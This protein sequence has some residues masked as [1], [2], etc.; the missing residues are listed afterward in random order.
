MYTA[1]NH[2]RQVSSQTSS[3]DTVHITT[4]ELLTCTKSF[5]TTLDVMATIAVMVTFKPTDNWREIAALDTD[6]HCCISLTMLEGMVVQ[7]HYIVVNATCEDMELKLIES[8]GKLLH[9]C[10]R[11]SDV[12]PSQLKSAVTTDHFPGDGYPVVYSNTHRLTLCLRFTKSMA[13]KLSFSVLPASS[14][15]QLEVLR[16]SPSTGELQW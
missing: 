9:L 5:P 7:M 2:S 4:E 1:R 3:H 15:P 13:A 16:L 11:F 6:I 14:K 12:F 8:K 10:R